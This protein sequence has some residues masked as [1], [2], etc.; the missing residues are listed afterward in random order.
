MRSVNVAAIQMTCSWDIDANLKK[1]EHFIREAAGQG[2][3]IVL[4][5]E[6]YETPYFCIEI[7]LKHLQLARSL[8]ASH[9][10]VKLQQLADE[11][12]IVLPYSFYERDDNLRYN[13]LAMID[14]DGEHLGTYRKT[15]IPDTDGY[16]EKYYFAPG[17]TGFMVFETR[18]CRVGA[19]ICWDQWFPETARSLALKGAE[20]MLFPTAIGSEPK[21]PELDCKGHWQQVM[22]G[23]AAA[24]QVPVVAA[25]RVGT[26]K[27]IANSNEITFFGSSFVAD[28]TGHKIA[29]ANRTDETVLV[30][31]LDLEAAQLARD[32]WGI[33][34]D[35]RPSH[36]GRLLD[37]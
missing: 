23:H 9:H 10:F 7:D 29:E 2:A 35:R 28:H 20:V 12:N 5:Q 8:S 31:T 3:Q 26:E 36:Y 1:I 34:R 6:L 24:N 30:Q 18:Y 16:L 11:L 33:Y 15:H 27:A 25:N 37:L 13:S 22:Q 32:S 4:L 14:A 21:Q 17:N 19:A